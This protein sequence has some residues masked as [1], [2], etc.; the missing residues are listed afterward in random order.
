MVFWCLRFPPKNE[1]KQVD[2][3]Y[4]SSKVEFLRSFF[5]GNRR[6]QK[7]FQIYLTFRTCNFTVIGVYNFTCS[8]PSYWFCRFGWPG[9]L[10]TAL[11]TKTRLFCFCTTTTFPLFAFLQKNQKFLI[12]KWNPDLR[13][14]DLRKNLDLRKIVGTTDFLVHKLFDLR[15]IF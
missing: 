12:A 13:K 11:S 9:R 5:G 8:A 3:R 14:P 4:H 1:R 7:P 10:C 2:L 15:K 6:H